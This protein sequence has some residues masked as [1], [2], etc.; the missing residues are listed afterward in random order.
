MPYV[1]STATAGND[2]TE[3]RHIT[4]DLNDPVKKVSIRGG[5]NLA[6]KQVITPYGV[7]TEVSE[8]DLEFLK[9][10]PVFKM[11]MEAGYIRFDESKK[12]P[13]RVITET[14]MEI[15]DNSA[16]ETPETLDLKNRQAKVKDDTKK[17]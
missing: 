13:E 15:R 6:D 7:A 17:K 8:D 12:D 5:S 16:P 10:H 4:K 3:Y 2:Y 14:A 1:Y 11:H 9:N